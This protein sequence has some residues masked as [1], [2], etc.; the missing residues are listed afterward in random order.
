[1]NEGKQKTKPKQSSRKLKT[2][3]A[4]EFIMSDVSH[5]A[6]TLDRILEVV[7]GGQG[8]ESKD[9]KRGIPKTQTN[10]SH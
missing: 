5:I 7:S 8:F 10:L 9:K 4:L 2:S 6:N 1:M 3:D